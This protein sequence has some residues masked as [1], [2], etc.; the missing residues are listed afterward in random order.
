MLIHELKTYFNYLKLPIAM[1][2]TEMCE[3]V[4]HWH[5]DFE[6]AFILAG[7]II[8]NINGEIRSLRAGDTLLC[9]DGDIHSYSRS[10]ED[11]QVIILMIDPIATRK[12]GM[13]VLDSATRSCVYH[14]AD[15]GSGA[16]L[17]ELVLKMYREYSLMNDTSTYFLYAYI[18]EALGMLHRYYL[19]REFQPGSPDRQTHLYSIR[20]SISYIEDHIAGEITI[21]DMAKRALM[22]VSNY[23]H[24]FKDITGTGFREYVNLLRL[25][26]VTAAMKEGREG[27][28]QIA[29]DCGFKSVRTFNRVFFSHYRMT[30]SA[31]CR[32][33]RKL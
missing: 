1:L 15:S 22:S 7:S 21:M 19:K 28:A 16:R 30:P 10:S 13:T 26:D 6:V 29:Y 25:R 20:E 11:S 31:Y 14:P 4:S 9:S 24:E 27:I 32:S 12:N 23:S 5:Y 3:Y 17:E 18:L 33:L 8:V 2:K